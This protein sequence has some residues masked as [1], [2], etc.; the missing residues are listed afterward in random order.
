MSAMAVLQRIAAEWGV[1]SFT[2]EHMTNLPLRALR[3][4]E[5][6]METMQSFDVPFDTALAML[7]N[8]YSKPKGNPWQEIGG[9]LM[10]AVMLCEVLGKPAEE[11]LEM[12]VRRVLAKPPKF[13]ADRNK[14]KLDLGLDVPKQDPPPDA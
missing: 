11:V 6:A 7:K 13:F 12:E 8:V 3:H 9:S 4:G 2:E 14:A 10:T 1:R 5:E